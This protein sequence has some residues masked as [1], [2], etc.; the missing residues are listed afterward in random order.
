MQLPIQRSWQDSSM[1]DPALAHRTLAKLK[2][3]AQRFPTTREAY[4]AGYHPNP[5]AKDH[6]INDKVFAVRNGF[7]LESPATLMYDNA[8]KLVGVMLSHDPRKGPPPDLGA[9]EWHTHGGTTGSELSL[10][11]WFNRP[12]ERAFG[13]KH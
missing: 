7:D 12:I 9:G 13:D 10:H 11:V 6:F 4:A 1:R 2:E 5:S 3:L 8:G